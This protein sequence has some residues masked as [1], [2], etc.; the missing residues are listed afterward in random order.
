MSNQMTEIPETASLIAEKIGSYYHILQ[1]K[2]E[3]HKIIREV[4]EAKLLDYYIEENM[5]EDLE[6]LQELLETGQISEEEA[7]ETYEKMRKRALF[8]IDRHYKFD[9][10]L[11]GYKS[12]ST[13]IWDDAFN[14]ILLEK[15]ILHKAKSVLKKDEA[16]FN[17]AKFASP[18]DKY[19][20]IHE[21]LGLS[22]EEKADIDAQLDEERKALKKE[23]QLQSFDELIATFKE[24][25]KTLQSLET[26]YEQDRDSLFKLMT[27]ENL[28]EVAADD[29]GTL[30][31]KLFERASGYDTAKIAEATIEKKFLYFYAIDSSGTV[32]CKDW[33]TKETFSF[34]KET[35]HDGHRILEKHGTIYVDDTALMAPDIQDVSLLKKNDYKEIE[36]LKWSVAYGEIPLNGLDYLKQCKT[37]TSLV[38]KLIDE[39]TLPPNVLDRY[40][41]MGKEEDIKLIFEMI[42][43]EADNNRKFFF[44]KKRQKRVARY[45]RLQRREA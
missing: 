29:E 36:K 7:A 27:T 24:N 32:S 40:R 43:Q 38:E 22:K 26:L 39:G 23:L 44:V 9:D 4:A 41:Y 31:F 21:S 16:R 14:E 11:L 5:E 28:T 30:S 34:S 15:K 2:K 10:I 35:M 17:I 18:N 3:L 45:E 1:E 42:E 20:K 12:R 19:L 6:E 37:S 8:L 13:K 33:F 25:K